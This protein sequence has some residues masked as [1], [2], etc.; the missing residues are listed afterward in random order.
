MFFVEKM[1]SNYVFMQMVYIHSYHCVLD[2]K[3][4]FPEES[5]DISWKPIPEYL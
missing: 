3:Y 5:E 4:H 1:Q 2:L